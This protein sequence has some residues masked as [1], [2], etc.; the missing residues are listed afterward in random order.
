MSVAS[1]ADPVAINEHFGH[2]VV[3]Q[4]L[5]RQLLELLDAPVLQLVDDV[6]RV[7]AHRDQSHQGKILHKTT[8]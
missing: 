6:C 1:Q 5:C 3:A 4:V 2:L 8:G 7:R